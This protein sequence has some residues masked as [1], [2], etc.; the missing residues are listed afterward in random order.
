MSFSKGD[1]SEPLITEEEKANLED[2]FK[3]NFMDDELNLSEIEVPKE[4]VWFKVKFSINKGYI[5]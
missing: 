5:I 2:Y 1:I 4:Y 3:K